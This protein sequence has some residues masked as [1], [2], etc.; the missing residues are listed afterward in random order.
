MPP[1]WK[2]ETNSPVNGLSRPDGVESPRRA[3]II[4]PRAISARS[5]RIDPSIC[6][7]VLTLGRRMSLK[8]AIVFGTRSLMRPVTT[9][10]WWRFLSAFAKREAL[11]RPH[12]DLLRKSISTFFLHRASTRFRLRLLVEHFKIAAEVMTFDVLRAL[13]AGDAVEVGTVEGRNDHYKIHVMLADHCGSRHEGAFAIRLS[14]ARD[15]F[16]LCIASFLFVRCGQDGHGIAIGGMQGPRDPGGKRALITATRCLGGLRPKDAVLLVLQGTA[17]VG[18]AAQIL[19][20]SNANHVVNLRRRK[21]R[22]LML[23]NLDD[24]WLERGGEPTKAFGFRLPIHAFFRTG[25]ESRRDQSKL[26][27]W[28]AGAW[29]L[30]KSP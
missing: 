15:G 26:A 7:Q 12:D 20:V 14:R 29:L 22:R 18:R 16:I 5:E 21:R 13:W 2:L 8:K 19:A 1:V 10:R 28:N 30:S 3:S 27:F 24:Y 23:A 17:E 4:P 9:L 11:G 25:G 6:R